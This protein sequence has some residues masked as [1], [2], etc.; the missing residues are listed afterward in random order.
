[1]DCKSMGSFAWETHPARTGAARSRQIPDK[2][3]LRVTWFDLTTT[4]G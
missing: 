1:M 3:P 2:L 4:V